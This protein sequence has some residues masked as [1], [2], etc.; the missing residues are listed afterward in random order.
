M[1]IV[2]GH[3][4]TGK[5]T[6]NSDGVM[7]LSCIWLEKSAI[8]TPI[9]PASGCTRA[10]NMRYYYWPYLLLLSPGEESCRN[11]E[12]ASQVVSLECMSSCDLCVKVSQGRI[13][14]LLQW[15]A[16]KVVLQKLLLEKWFMLNIKYLEKYNKYFWW[17]WF[18]Y[19][20]TFQ[21][22]RVV[23]LQTVFLKHQCAYIPQMMHINQLPE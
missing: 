9:V 16:F 19:V 7:R 17:Q 20:P 13:E 21:Y 22:R 15:H 1:P 23:K 2:C 12:S 18:I 5:F 11:T 8:L 3:F 6:K 4:W 14:A 10:C